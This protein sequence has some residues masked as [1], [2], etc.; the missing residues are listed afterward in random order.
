MRTYAVA[1]VHPNN[2]L[3]TRVDQQGYNNPTWNDRFAFRVDDEL[4]FSDQSAVTVEIY[5]VSWF[6]DVL[7]G[8]VRVLMSNLITPYAKN[9]TRFVALQIRRPSGNPQGKLNMGVAL[10]DASKRSMP[11]CREIN[12]SVTDYHDVLQKKVSKMGLEDQNGELSAHHMYDKIQLWRSY[13]V[14]T[15]DVNEEFPAKA[16]SICNGSMVNGSMCNGSMVNGSELCSDVGPSASIVA[17]EI[18]QKSQSRPPTADK[19]E[20]ISHSKQELLDNHGNSI[21]EDLTVEEAK[22]KG[23]TSNVARWKKEVS[24]R[25][26]NDETSEAKAAESIRRHSRRHSDGGLFS[27]FGNAYGFEFTIVCGASNSGGKPKH[28]KSQRRRLTSSEANSA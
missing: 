6:R 9:S 26:G 11:I 15:S 21:V 1:W 16:G 12:G 5:T 13:S 17:A 23:L 20:N 8:T 14:G 10:M 24:N 25:D 18:A 2:K 27:C 4:L 22:A 3:T 19:P 28:S 7:V